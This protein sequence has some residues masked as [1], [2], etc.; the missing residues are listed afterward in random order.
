VVRATLVTRHGGR[1]GDRR[2]RSQVR[3]LGISAVVIAESYRYPYLAGMRYAAVDVL[4]CGRKVRTDAAIAFLT[5][6]FG[7]TP[8]ATTLARATGSIAAARAMPGH[9]GATPPADRFAP[10]RASGGWGGRQCRTKL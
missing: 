8:A 9:P 3:A 1:R 2:N 6:A 5:R 10:D 7:Q 4:T